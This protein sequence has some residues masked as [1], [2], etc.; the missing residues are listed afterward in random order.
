MATTLNPHTIAGVVGRRTLSAF[1]YVLDLTVFVLRIVR[2]WRGRGSLF[3][4]ATRAAVVSQ[5]IFSGVDALPTLTLL[6]AA[7][8]LSITAQLILLIQVVGSDADTVAILSQVVALELGAL[9]PAFI[10]I[11]RS[12]SAIAVD[13]GNM[14][15]NKEIEGLEQ[16]GINLND[17]FLTPRLIGTAIAQMA[18]A[19]YFSV[20]AVVAGVLFAG[21]LESMTFYKLLGQFLGVFSPVEIVAFMVKNLLFGLI[22][23]ATACFHGLRVQI[24]STELPQETQRAI[25]NSL[26]LVVLVDGILAV[27]I[28]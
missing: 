15:L 19:V 3:N 10:L 4:R 12:G 11:G 8:G 23:G 27:L 1:T 2:S 16:L 26:V 9:L 5:I 14:K 22:I 20:I 18:L 6:A 28:R 25:V 7:I 24:S 21:M 13:L 17:F